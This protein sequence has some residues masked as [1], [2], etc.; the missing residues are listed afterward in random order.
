MCRLAG[1]IDEA[2]AAGRRAIELNP[3]YAG[4]LSNLGIA[5][6][7]QGKFDEALSLYDR[8]IALESNFAQAYSNRG[9]AL[10]R[11]KRFAEAEKDYRRA[12]ELQPS[13]ADAWNNLGTCLRE[14]KRSGGGGD[15][16]SQGARIHI[17]TIPTRS[18][19]WRWRSRTSTGSTRPPI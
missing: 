15:R 19:I 9:N 17:R 8:A 3:N 12:I 7:D 14:L 5:L 4:A 11:L 13:F 2:I 18:T 6:F 10:Q 16:L 1:R